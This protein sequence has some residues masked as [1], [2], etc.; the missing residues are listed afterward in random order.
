MDTIRAEARNNDD[1]AIFN[2]D[3]IECYIETPERSYFK[4][5][6]NANGAVW[7]ESQDVSIVTRDTLPRLWNP[8]IKAAVK[9]EKDQWTV[10]MMIPVKDFGSLGPTKVYPWG[11]NV[12]RTRWAS[13]KPECYAI[14]PTGQM[15]FGVLSK[16][17]NLH[18][19]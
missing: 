2:D 19:Q 6:V 18:V 5:A 10:E 3:R 9:K 14:A 13:G 16:L 8:G 12:C 4:I 1:V 11:I 15:C 7:D 17:G